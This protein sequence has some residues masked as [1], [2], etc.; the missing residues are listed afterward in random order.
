MGGKIG[1]GECG[2]KPAWL[3][4]K[5]VLQGMGPMQ[6]NLG[7]WGLNTVCESARC[8]N[9]S[10]CFSKKTAT[11][12]IMGNVCTRSCKF[13]A[14]A[15]GRP[16]PLDPAEPE[17][18][19]LWAKGLGLKYIVI[20]SVDRD[21]LADFGAGHFA[22]TVR[23]V[24]IH[25]PDSAVE[26][27]TPDFQGRGEF[28][29]MV[30]GS[31]PKV[32]NHN[33]ET[34]ERLTPVV[35][36]AAKYGRSL[37]VLDHVKK[38]FPQMFTKSGLMLGLGESKDEVVRTMKDLRRNGC[39]FLT[40][41]QYLQPTAKHLAVSEYINPDRFCEY[42]QIGLDLGFASVLS[43]PFVRSSYHAGELLKNSA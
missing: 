23:K 24:K 26:V 31:G 14:V 34:V 1:T 18:T 6:G 38:N 11:I 22:E 15:T 29:N 27:L 28:V 30:C 21:D 17:N 36:S 25:N 9:I 39:D 3:K 42:R 12:M 4:K 13:C 43:G 41:G 16:K 5:L 37:S 10:E 35:R 32:Y 33:I 20:T 19:A 40:L 8:P 7:K 2:V